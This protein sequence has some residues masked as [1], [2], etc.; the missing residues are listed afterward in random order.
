MLDR[1]FCY[2]GSRGRRPPNAPAQPTASSVMALEFTIGWTAVTSATGYYVDVATDS[3]F[4]NILSSYDDVFTGVNS[5][6][7]NSGISRN[8]TYYYR[9]RAMNG[10]GTSGNSPFNS[11]LTTNPVITVTDSDPYNFGSVAAGT[12]SGSPVSYSVSA[13]GLDEDLTITPPAGY[14]A[15]T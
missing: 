9:V 1:L 5:I 12:C 8:T 14:K 3:N 7:V 15:V 10:C 6:N 4:T 2:T 13:T 11:V